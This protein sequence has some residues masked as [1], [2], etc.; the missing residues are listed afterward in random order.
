MSTEGHVSETEGGRAGKQRREVID[1]SFP[2]A[3]HFSH[4]EDRNLTEHR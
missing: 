2:D 4:A 1:E 3:H